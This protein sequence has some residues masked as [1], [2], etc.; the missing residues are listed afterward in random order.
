MM[1]CRP[2]DKAVMCADPAAKYALRGD[3]PCPLI[4][5]VN[6]LLPGLSF[7]VSYVFSWV[8]CFPCRY[9]PVS[10]LVFAHDSLKIDY[11]KIL[12]SRRTKDHSC[13][14]QLSSHML[15]G[16]L[17]CLFI[18]EQKSIQNWVSN[19]KRKNLK[20]QHVSTVGV[21]WRNSVSNLQPS[22]NTTACPWA[23]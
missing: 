9:T 14:E 21:D 10:C 18:Q 13:S 1:T 22:K 23:K 7:I 3:S 20:S 12:H 2:Q 17:V 8:P 15:L 11:H 16:C 6:I 19:F 5:M 4:C